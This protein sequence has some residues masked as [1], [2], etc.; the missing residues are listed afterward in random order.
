MDVVIAILRHW[1]RNTDATRVP[2]FFPSSYHRYEQ[3]SLYV[4]FCFRMLQSIAAADVERTQQ[5]EDAGSIFGKQHQFSAFITHFNALTTTH[6]HTHGPCEYTT[7]YW[8]AHL[9]WS[10]FTT[11]WTLSSAVPSTRYCRK[12][13]PTSCFR[14]SSII[15]SMMP[16]SIPPPPPLPVWHAH[17]P[18]ST[19]RST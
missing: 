11:P 13:H 9:Q 12:A 16:F 19:L 1:F 10:G 17:W 6:T 18:A 4:S 3:S 15:T 2:V 7:E 14:R 8:G 5:V